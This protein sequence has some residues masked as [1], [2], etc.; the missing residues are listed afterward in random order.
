MTMK[1]QLAA[2]VAAFS[3]I[4]ASQVYAQAPAQAPAAPLGVLAAARTTRSGSR[5][6]RVSS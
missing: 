3:L 4:A 5:R 1:K 6:P 2:A